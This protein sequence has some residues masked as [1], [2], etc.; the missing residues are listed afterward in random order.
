MWEISQKKFFGWGFILKEALV[1][2][3]PQ[4]AWTLRFSQKV[5]KFFGP[6]ITPVFPKDF[7]GNNPQL[8]KPVEFFQPIP[9]V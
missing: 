1:G 2:N 3:A 7:L 5:S 9:Q 4:L 8:F 6:P